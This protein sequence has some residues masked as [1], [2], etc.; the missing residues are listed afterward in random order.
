VAERDER[1]GLAMCDVKL[2][3]QNSI[4]GSQ[5][6]NSRWSHAAAS[7]DADKFSASIAFV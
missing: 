6:L 4:A 2:S 5:G 3:V 1:G 7:T